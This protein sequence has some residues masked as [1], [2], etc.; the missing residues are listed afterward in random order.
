MRDWEKGIVKK[1][2]TEEQLK[3]RIKELGAQI[4]KDYENDDADFIVVGILKCSILFM[5]YLIR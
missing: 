3:E 2:A 5:A 1:I 4:T